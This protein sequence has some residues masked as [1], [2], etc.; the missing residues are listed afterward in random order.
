MQ[1]YFL[2]PMPA[3]D[4]TIDSYDRA[5]RAGYYGGFTYGAPAPI[6]DLAAQ[7]HRLWKTHTQFARFT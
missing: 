5:H 6:T 2:G 1:A 4:S 3:P 7:F